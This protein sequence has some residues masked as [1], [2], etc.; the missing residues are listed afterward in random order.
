MRKARLQDAFT[1]GLV[2]NVEPAGDP[3][4]STANEVPESL[5][6]LQE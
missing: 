2:T 5:P 4:F 6:F 3:T 1:D